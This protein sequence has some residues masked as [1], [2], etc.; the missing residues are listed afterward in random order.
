MDRTPDRGVQ[1]GD[2]F[3]S[4]ER[5]LEGA[6]ET[7]NLTSTLTN[8]FGDT[9]NFAKIREIWIANRSATTLE[10]LTLTGTFIEALIGGASPAPTVDPLG[11]WIRSSPIDGY[12]TAG[13]T[14][15]TV[16]PGS[17]TITYWLMILGVAA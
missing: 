1:Q 3:F 14:E 15:L 8:K 10:V 11:W 6:S 5:T 13:A 4:D 2:E 9:A 17:D 12:N 7:I 16:D